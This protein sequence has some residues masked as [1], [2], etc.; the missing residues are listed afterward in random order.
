[1][2]LLIGGLTSAVDEVIGVVTVSI[3]FFIGCG[4]PA[5]CGLI[6]CVMLFELLLEVSEIEKCL[7]K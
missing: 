2:Y 4:G 1:M 7:E 5:I 3:T 6:S